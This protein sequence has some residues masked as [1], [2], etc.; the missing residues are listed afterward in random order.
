MSTM[1]FAHANGFPSP[2]YSPFF[3]A[4]QSHGYTI[5]SIEKIGLDSKFP[6]T[7]NWQH[8]VE[9]L[10][11]EITSRHQAP[12]IGIGHSLGGL[13]SYLLANKR[14]DLYSH[15]ILLD[16]PVINGWQNIIWWL[17]KR[18]G[19]TEK[20][21]PAR[22]SKN[23]RTHFANYQDAYE[24]LRPKRLFRDFTEASFEAY[25]QH[26][27]VPDD[28]GG[29]TLAIDLDT[30]L[31][32]FRTASD[33]LWRYRGKL[34]MPGLYLTAEGSEFA[35]RPFAKNLSTRA[36]LDFRVVKGGHLFPQELPVE[37]AAIITEWLQTKNA[38]TADADSALT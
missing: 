15:L 25:L 36:G 27:L 32:L 33:D 17:S 5:D 21:T 28:M 14:P 1:F 30:E 4:F 29:L 23:R 26:G 10:E 2:S 8:L 3:E 31:A 34:K 35:R 20:F 12:V 37:T 22:I 19:M 9:Q 11:Q 18:F 24:N 16:P 6:I 13:L 7:N 38:L